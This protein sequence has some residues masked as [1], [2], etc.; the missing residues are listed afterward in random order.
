MDTEPFY[1]LRVSKLTEKDIDFLM[2]FRKGFLKPEST[3]EESDLDKFESFSRK[4]YKGLQ[5]GIIPDWLIHTIAFEAKC[6]LAN[7]DTQS[8]K[9]VFSGIL[10]S[11]SSIDTKVEENRSVDTV[12]PI[13]LEQDCERPKQSIE[14]TTESKKKR[15]SFD[16]IKLNHPYVFTDYSDGHWTGHRLEKV[17][18]NGTEIE[19][20][21][22]TDM[23][24]KVI[25][26]LLDSN[27]VTVRD[28]INSEDVL[29]S[30]YFSYTSLDRFSLLEKYNLYVNLNLSFDYIV[31]LLQG[32]FIW[33]DVKE[34]TLKFVFKK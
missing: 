18:L 7:I 22:A 24:L 28:L 30:R 15:K 23:A 27:I 11:S 25:T 2:S 12:K 3:I 31:K 19:V 32:L 10:N 33:L 34:D 8:A 29:G 26:Y 13:D 17:I 20:N 6:D 4:F 1:I 14:D 9:K 16:N 5:D 21:N